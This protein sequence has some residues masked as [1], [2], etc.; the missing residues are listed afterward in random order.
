[1]R[2]DKLLIFVC[3]ILFFSCAT[4]DYIS[5]DTLLSQKVE[6]KAGAL[7]MHQIQ[8]Q[9]GNKEQFVR[10]LNGHTPLFNYVT[11]SSSG[12]YGLYYS[13]PYAN[14]D[15]E[16]EGCIIYPVDT[17]LSMEQRRIGGTLGTLVNMDPDFLNGKVDLSTRYLYSAAFLNWQNN[18]LSVNSGLTAHA[19]LLNAGPVTQNAQGVVSRSGPYNQ[20]CGKSVMV[21][22]WYNLSSTGYSNG[23][24][25]GVTTLSPETVRRIFD[26]Y[27][28]SH[29]NGFYYQ[30]DEIQGWRIELKMMFDVDHNAEQVINILRPIMDEIVKTIYGKNIIFQAESMKI[31]FLDSH[32]G[33]FSGG[34]GGSGSGSSSGHYGGVGGG[35]KQNS[36]NDVDYPK[37]G[38][39]ENCSLNEADKK[40]FNKV[41][42]ELFTQRC[43]FRYMSDILS[44]LHG[45][46]SDVQYRTMSSTAQYDPKKNI[47]YVSKDILLIREGFPEEYIHMFQN[48]MYQ[49]TYKYAGAVGSTNIDFE[50]KFI[51]D[52]T[53]AIIDYGGGCDYA[54]GKNYSREYANWIYSLGDKGNKLTREIIDEGYTYTDPVTK[55]KKTLHYEDFLEDF[56]KRFDNDPRNINYS[57][58]HIIR[59]MRTAALDVVISNLTCN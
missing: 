35:K 26:G 33:S 46:F 12:D 56:G 51:R 13:V 19:E 10:A 2:K 9:K 57:S 29:S 5:N 17:N 48:Y 7:L 23:T 30:I 11:V 39:Y 44:G 42:K 54:K 8:T 49:G 38:I 20:E 22:I 41:I 59:G 52:I 53:C 40:L 24:D 4:D 47:F 58:S 55:E 31:L 45:G 1:M 37:A 15:N 16:V 27:L 25:F 21:Y 18:G 28:W 32:S 3:S 43:G 14:S 36:E 6:N 50:A 34:G